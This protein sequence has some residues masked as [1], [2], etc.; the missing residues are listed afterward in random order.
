MRLIHV[1]PCRCNS[2]YYTEIAHALSVIIYPLP[3]TKEK[4]KKMNKENQ[5]NLKQ[6]LFYTVPNTCYRFIFAFLILQNIHTLA[7]TMRLSS[8]QF[9]KQRETLFKVIFTS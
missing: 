2:I 5:R 6:S 8:L 4:K 3:P 9:F 7:S 1:C